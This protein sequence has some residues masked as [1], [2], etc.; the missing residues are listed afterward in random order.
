MPSRASSTRTSWTP[1]W[2]PSPAGWDAWDLMERLQQDGIPAGPAASVAD[3][4]RN[5]PPAGAGILRNL[6]GER[7]R[8]NGAGAPHRTLALRRKGRGPHHRPAPPGTAQ[9]LRLR[10]ASRPPASGNS[11]PRRGAGHLLRPGDFVS[12]QGM[13]EF[14]AEPPAAA[15]AQSFIAGMVGAGGLGL[16]RAGRYGSSDKVNT[17][18]I[19]IGCGGR[20]RLAATA[21]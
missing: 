21:D 9:L 20:N 10:G 2:P 12:L 14:P 16:V 8:R 7:R 13:G 19:H 17:V 6:P 11:P 1:A 18:K 3:L 4:W 15:E 5:P